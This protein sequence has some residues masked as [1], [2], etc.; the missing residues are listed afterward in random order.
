MGLPGLARVCLRDKR[1]RVSGLAR[2][3]RVLPLLGA[4]EAEPETISDHLVA[5]QRFFCGHPFSSY[6]Y[7]GWLGAVRRV[8]VDHHYTEHPASHGLAIIDLEA[9]RVRYEVRGVGWRRAGWLYYH[10][11]E[12]FTSRRVTYRIP[13]SWLIEG[14]SEDRTPAAEWNDGGPEAFSFLLPPA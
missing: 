10:D 3:W 1:R 13:E 7:E 2:P 14:A 11:G 9:R 12:G 8:G 5:A 4:L 6:T